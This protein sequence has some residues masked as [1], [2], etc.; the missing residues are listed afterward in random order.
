MSHYLTEA[1]KTSDTTMNR[2]MISKL[3]FLTTGCLNRSSREALF[4]LKQN[5]ILMFYEQIHSMDLYTDNYLP[6]FSNDLFRLRGN[7]FLLLG[8]VYIPDFI[9]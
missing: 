3:F 4:S 2:K 9:G 1:S 8:C 7:C 5:L 6:L